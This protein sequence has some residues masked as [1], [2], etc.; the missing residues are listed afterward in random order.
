MSHKE[1]YLK[2]VHLE[3]PD[4]IP[5]DGTNL[6]PIHA[7][8][9]L[10]KTPMSTELLL[11]QWGDVDMNHITRHNQGLVNEVAM[12]LGFDSLM[13]NDWHLYP[14]N[15][16]PIFRDNGSYID[17]LGRVFRIRP[18][19]RTTYW[20]DGIVKSPEDLNRLELPNPEELNFGIVDT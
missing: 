15:F 5:V 20:V 9:L 1:R 3:V 2:T 4:M 17:H 13:V 11:S 12:E 8:R 16:R 7:Q 10:G 6:D 19:V 14:E 18:D